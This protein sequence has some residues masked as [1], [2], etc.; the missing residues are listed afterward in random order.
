MVDRLFSVVVVGLGYFSRF[1]LAAWRAAPSAA[2]VGV[3]DQAADRLASVQGLD[4]VARSTDPTDILD[5][6]RPDIVDV[7]APPHAHAAIIRAALEPGRMIICQKPFCT[8]IAQARS[9]IAEAE[10]AGT[11]IVIHENFRFQPWHRQIKDFLQAGRMGA[12]FQARFDLRP[13][14][15]RGPHA[16][17]DR[18][19][20]FQ[21]MPRFLLH[22]TGVHL[23]DL[24]RWLFGDVTSVYADIQTLNPVI[25]GEDAGCVMLHHDSGVRSLF[26]GN[27]LADHATDNPRRTMGEMQIEGEAGCLRLF[28]DGRLR[29]RPFGQSEEETI[30]LTRPV[31]EL[32]FGGGCVAALINHVLSAHQHGHVPENTAKEYLHVM[33]VNEGAY[34]SAASGKKI[35]IKEASQCLSSA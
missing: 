19:P 3:C 29:F 30:P 17:L 8:S 21:T 5:R 4:D 6:T 25:A 13:G 7:V 34:R 14:D 33:E 26:D 11:Q 2:L 1:H 31:D 12:V 35:E 23:F 24:F 28:G 27:R 22:E 9:I 20:A 18:Q 16:Y 32:S 10:A 15:G